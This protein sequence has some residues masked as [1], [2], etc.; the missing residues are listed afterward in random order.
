MD[1]NKKQKK[2][3]FTIGTGAMI[4]LMITIIIQVAFVGMLAAINILPLLYIGI[5][6]AVLV[7]VNAGVMAMLRRGK[8]GSTK[9]LGSMVLM[10]LIVIVMLMGCFYML[11]T[12]DT[13]N[14]I[15]CDGRQ[16]EDFH[17]VVLKESKYQAVEDIEGKEVYCKDCYATMKEANA[18]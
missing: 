1:N 18:Q 14:K 2:K 15:S 3:K 4:V 6:I 5:L 9:R 13:F 10:I 8:K 12:F 7:L 17:V 11:N 16:M